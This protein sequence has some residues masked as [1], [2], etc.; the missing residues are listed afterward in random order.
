MRHVEFNP[1]S[2]Q[3]NLREEWLAWE[4]KAIQATL[5]AIE[6]WERTGTVTWRQDIWSEWKRW[7][8]ENVFNNK[9]A[10][11]ETRAVRD[12]GDAEHFRPKGRVSVA[13]PLSGGKKK[14]KK[15]RIIDPS[16]KEIDH[17]GYFWLAYNWKNLLPA[18]RDCNSSEGK[19]DQFPIEKEHVFLMPLTAR[20]LQRMR[21]A[22]PSMRWSGYF[23]LDPDDLDKIEG[24]LLLHPYLDHPET[25]VRFGFRGIEAP[26]E[27]SR[28][29]VVSI[30]V[31]KL[32]ADTLRQAREG[33]QTAGFN[34]FLMAMG[35]R[36]GTPDENFQAA[37]DAVRD[38]I[39][40]KGTYSA[41]VCDWIE[42]NF[43]RIR[44][45]AAGA[46]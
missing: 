37:C 24:R 28:K 42:A 41:A 10:Y 1:A 13:E 34:R 9:C 16:G 3:G 11:C 5:D 46:P 19:R 6:E 12:P 23:Y 7:L 26:A 33:E 25:E 2:L 17:P 38:Y 4:K 29:A 27:G 39:I 32:D 20:D 8:L 30:E 44:Q 45:A 40:G 15:I 43:R 14:L 35:A 18:C 36:L 31:Y 21:S 22:L